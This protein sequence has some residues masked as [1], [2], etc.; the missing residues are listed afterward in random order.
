M[1][2]NETNET[3]RTAVHEYCTPS[4]KQ[5]TIAKYGHIKDWN[6]T[7]VT[8]M[9]HLFTNK[10]NFNEDIRTWDVSNVTN[11]ESMFSYA[12]KFNQPL[13]VPGKYASLVQKFNQPLNIV[14]CIQRDNYG[15]YVLWRR[16][17]SI[18]LSTLGTCP[19]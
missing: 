11:M 1:F 12:R 2:T 13:N 10:Q 3:L 19:T 4:T 16:R 17:V 14:E 9:S 7:R 8:N 5:A 18:N 15:I 6:V